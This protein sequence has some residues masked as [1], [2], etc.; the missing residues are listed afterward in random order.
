MRKFCQDEKSGH[1]DF[2]DEASRFTGQQITFALQLA[3]QVRWPQLVDFCYI[4]AVSA[5]IMTI[6]YRSHICI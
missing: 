3:E 4:F 2:L 6:P 5:K 1:E